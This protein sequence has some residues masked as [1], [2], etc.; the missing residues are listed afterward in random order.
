MKKRI[1]C[2]LVFSLLTPL[3]LSAQPSNY[4]K[5]GVNYS[6]FRT[7]GG[8]SKPGLT[9]GFGKDFHPIRS[10]SGFFGFNLY[11]VT[12]KLKLENKTWPGGLD[13]GHSNAQVG[14]IPLDRSYL[15]FHT[16]LGYSF[17]LSHNKAA[18]GLFAGPLLSFPIKYL[19][20]FLADSTIFLDPDDRGKY[21]FDYLRCESEGADKILHWFM[22]I[23]AIYKSFGIEIRY[24]R[25]SRQ[26]CIRGLTI[27]DS[28]DSFHVMLLYA[29]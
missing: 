12:K 9:F 27:N 29:F 6:S 14:D 10:F 11:Y 24:D 2:F 4:L 26:K 8:K 17:S 7:E 5:L 3:S 18:I 19:S 25:A 28:L 21:E 1:T 16:K 20:R 23:A 13:P 15:E 22:G